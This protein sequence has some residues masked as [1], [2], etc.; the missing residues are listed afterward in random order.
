MR[1]G[2]GKRKGVRKRWKGKREEGKKRRGGTE[3]KEGGMRMKAAI[4]AVPKAIKTKHQQRTYN[5]HS[6]RVS[7]FMHTDISML[8]GSRSYMVSTQTH[9]TGIGSKYALNF[10]LTIVKQFVCY[11]T[12]Q[13]GS[14]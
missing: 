2:K 9:L 11:K 1:G 8:S 6:S 7:I 12:Q 10:P 4:L 13:K 14:N 3:G 5:P